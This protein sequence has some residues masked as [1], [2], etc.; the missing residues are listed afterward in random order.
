MYDVL[1]HKNTMKKSKSLRIALLSPY[2]GGNL[3]DAA[4]QEAV[5]DNIRKRYQN[6]VIY[7]ITLCPELTTKLHGVPSFPITPFAISHYAPVSS[8]VKTYN[9]IE[10]PSALDNQSL[11]NR[12]KK[13]IKNIP[14]FYLLLKFVQQISTRLLKGPKLI[15]QELHHM[16]QFYK[17]MKPIDLLIVSGGGQ[18]DD[19]WGGPWGHPYALL[20]WGL[21]AKVTG[22][23]YV[24][25]SVGTCALESKLSIF[26]IRQALKLAN[27]RSYRDKKSKQLLEHIDFTHNDLVYP[28][29]A[30]SYINRTKFQIP[31]G[32]NDGKVIGISPIAYLSRYGWPKKDIPVY[33][34]YFKALVVFISILIQ[35][36]Y[37]I[38]LFSTDGPDRKV[39][40]DIVD[41]LKKDYELD[42]TEKVSQPRTET[43][44]KLFE[45]LC[46]VNYV[47]ASRLHGILLSNLCGLPVLA[48]SYDRKVD[49]YMAD[50]G[51]PDYCL[52][53][54]N[55]ETGS[56]LK[57]FELLTINSDLIRSRIMDTNT[58]YTS[59]LK[60]QYDLVLDKE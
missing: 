48:I 1:C 42:I 54:H 6:V 3:G 50:V 30:F 23:R 43:L 41:S 40:S 10:D 15:Y 59:D 31:V 38:V 34:N 11:F 60:Q 36:G 45:Q 9:N 18:L 22:S 29:L 16:I 17:L 33:E 27:Y 21:I 2:T 24:F 57:S 58:N 25:L 20:K 56:L 35:Q 44:E 26:F 7:M 13:N 5:I 53:I 51:L 49:T 37:S 39:V 19:Y 32:Q 46:K 4:I 12:I 55:I 47:I 14:F 52:N 8:V 28:D